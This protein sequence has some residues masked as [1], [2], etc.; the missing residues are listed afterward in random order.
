MLLRLH[1]ARGARLAV[2]LAAAALASAASAHVAQ[3]SA[4]SPGGGYVVAYA[5]AGDRPLSSFGTMKLFVEPSAKVAQDASDA[6]A[7]QADARER[8]RQQ[9]EAIRRMIELI[10]SMNPNCAFWGC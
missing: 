10:A 8:Q 5:P 7:A 4:A 1:R 6:A 9:Q 2:V 3:A